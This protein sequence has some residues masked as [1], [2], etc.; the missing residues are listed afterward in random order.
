[1]NKI[2]VAK[3]LIRMIQTKI[4]YAKTPS[5]AMRVK[6]NELVENE[7]ERKIKTIGN[8]QRQHN[9]VSN[10]GIFLDAENS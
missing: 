2:S 10:K 9:F 6:T 1:M 5:K 8:E 7:A 3:E 4:N